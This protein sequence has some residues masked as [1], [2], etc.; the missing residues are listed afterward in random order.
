MQA[1]TLF[2]PELVGTLVGACLAVWTTWWWDRR[3]DKLD[4]KEH[5]LRIIDSLVGE[6]TGLRSVAETALESDEA[7]NEPEARPDGRIALSIDVF[8]LPNAAFQSAVGGGGFSRLP[9]DLQVT[10]SGFYETVA[11]ARLHR[12]NLVTSY[13][14][15]SSV[16][17]N[18]G[19]IRNAKTYFQ[20]GCGFI[21]Q[22]VDD[23]LEQLHQ[24]RMST[25][26]A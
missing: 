17:N 26:A 1:F 20:A 8:F 9:A 18:L 23:V 12:D 22:T 3:K 2:L 11:W 15:A 21:L 24:E 14:H 7:E 19:Y 5:K 25:D 10:L 4:K 13:S 16:E 6:I